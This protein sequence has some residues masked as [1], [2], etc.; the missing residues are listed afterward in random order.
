MKTSFSPVSA[1]TNA[2]GILEIGGCSCAE[3]AKEFGTPLYILDESTLRENARRYK[4]AL[5]KFYPNSEAIFACKALCTKAVLAI[6]RQEGFGVDVVSAGELHTARSVNFVPEKIYLHGNNKSRE[7]LSMLCESSKSKIV[8][9]NFNEL[10]LLKDIL[11][12]ESSRQIGILLRVA[13]GVECHTH[14][15]IKTGHLDSKFGFD[16]EQLDI[17]IKEVLENKNLKLLGL[18]A[19][20]GSQIFEIQPYIDLCEILL[21]KYSEIKEKYNIELEEL[22]IGGGIGIYYTEHDEPPFIEEALE[23]ISKKIKSECAER[24]LPEPKLIIEPGRSL[25]GNAGVT[26]YSIGST[27]QVPNGTFYVSVDGGMA[28]N[29]RVITYQAEYRVS[30]VKKSLNLELVDCRIAGRYCESGDVLIKKT[31][32]PNNIKAGD[33]LAIFA[34]GA[35][36]YSMSSN[37][38]RVPRPAMVLVNDGKAELILKRETLDELL[39]NDILPERLI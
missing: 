29:P 15:Y 35:Y 11:K 9:D 23:R 27:K 16:F 25:V 14:E 30:P 38:N 28:D 22:D 21:G 32:L 17:V 8:I 33:L 6:L 10:K 18:H 20:I 39:R 34:T 24:G 13:P 12:G 19:H 3:L 26:L 36:N 1:R 5:E 31:K 2:E 4:S 37:Y 7:E